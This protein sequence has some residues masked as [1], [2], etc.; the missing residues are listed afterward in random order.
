M[1]DVLPQVGFLESSRVM[2]RRG[3]AGV[4]PREL[5]VRRDDRLHLVWGFGVQR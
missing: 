4:S 3:H 1:L 5:V 2:G